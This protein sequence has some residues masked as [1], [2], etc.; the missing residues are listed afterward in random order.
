MI[1]DKPVLP[2]R[3]LAV[4]AK[5]G[6]PGRIDRSG[7]SPH[8]LADRRYGRDPRDRDGKT[9]KP[10]DQA[11]R[12]TEYRHHAGILSA[13]SHSAAF[14]ARSYALLNGLLIHVIDHDHWNRSPLFCQFQ[15]QFILDRI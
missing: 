11:E 12:G 13:E 14:P 8:R 9:K 2:F 4:I 10:E 15:P 3:G 1:L 5:Y 6:R 7:A